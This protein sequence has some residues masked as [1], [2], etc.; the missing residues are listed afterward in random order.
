MSQRAPVVALV[1]NL[2]SSVVEE[3]QQVGVIDCYEYDQVNPEL[4]DRA[5]RFAVRIFAMQQRLQHTQTAYEA[6]LE[7]SKC[8]FIQ[9][10]Q[11]GD[12]K[13]FPNV[14]RAY[15]S[16]RLRTALGLKDDEAFTLE[17]LLS[18]CRDIGRDRLLSEVRRCFEKEDRLRVLLRLQFGDARKEC[19]CEISGG[20]TTATLAKG[21]MGDRDVSSASIAVDEY[22]LN[23]LVRDVSSE[24]HLESRLRLMNRALELSGDGFLLADVEQGQARLSYASPGFLVNC[25]YRAQ[26]LIGEALTKL[27]GRD[28]DPQQEEELEAALSLGQHFF[29]EMIHYRADGSKFWDELKLSPV[30][31]ESGNYTNMV[32]VQRDVTERKR[33]ENQLERA[34]KMEAL[35]LLAGGIAHD[36]NNILSPLLGYTDLLLKDRGKPE[37]RRRWLET[38]HRSIMR[39][40]KLVERILAFARNKPSERGPVDL[41][42]LVEEVSVILRSGYPASIQMKVQCEE[43]TPM[44]VGDLTQLHQV[45]MNLAKNGCQA[46]GE[47]GLLTIELDSAEFETSDSPLFDHGLAAGRYARLRVTDTGPGI[48]PEVLPHILEPF[49][50]T[51]NSGGGTGL[52][53]AE[54]HSL[55]AAHGGCISV[56]TRLGTGTMFEILVP[57]QVGE[58]A[59]ASVEEDMPSKD[60][61]KPMDRGTSE[62][63]LIVDDEEAV[64]EVMQDVLESV[65]YQVCSA[66]C[67]KEAQAIMSRDHESID[68]LI[69]DH[70]LQDGKGVDLIRDLRSRGIDT[71]VVLST[72]AL[73]EEL[74]DAA[75][76]AGASDVIAKPFSFSDLTS[77]LTRVQQ[78]RSA[79]EITPGADSL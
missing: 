79:V 12:L 20:V 14:Q 23:A 45:V 13:E 38:I 68:I 5:L 53:L 44:I 77:A 49:F 33:L 73:T 8:G 59:P 28:T 63:I 37:E 31:D 25:G 46:M 78:A 58:E 6:A 55:V 48:P 76:S 21:V 22:V 41:R 54:V 74:S 26:E 62:M 18:R 3:L 1:E 43:Q 51:K 65:G 29:G 2:E 9:I 4:M 56:L 19:W 10:V 30:R 27:N 75:F 67:V 40:S 61:G 34:H 35:G 24:L 70:L 17:H 69:C 39:G 7:R 52:G 11:G 66:S 36:F 64:R 60:E 50:S 71:P 16:P 72:G 47:S 15:A 42:T 57:A 32:G